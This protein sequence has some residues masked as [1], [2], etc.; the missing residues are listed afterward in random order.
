MTSTLALRKFDPAE[1]PG[2]VYESFIE[3]IESFEYEYE[4]IAKQ[5]PAGTAD[6]PGWTAL[7]KRKQLLGRYASEPSEGLRG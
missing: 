3:F 6:V 2:N 4:A 1:H 7:D 5:P